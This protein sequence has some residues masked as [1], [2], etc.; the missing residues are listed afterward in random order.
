M[1][2]PKVTQSIITELGTV[3]GEIITDSADMLAE[4]VEILTPWMQ[5]KSTAERKMTLIVLRYTLRFL[6][7]LIY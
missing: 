6:F 1:L 5:S 7:F 2:S 4:V 3:C